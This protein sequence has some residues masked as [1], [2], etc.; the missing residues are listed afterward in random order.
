MSCVHCS[1]D[2]AALGDFNIEMCVL[3]C[4]IQAPE[5]Q[6]DAALRLL[7]PSDFATPACALVF[8]TISRRYSHGELVDPASLTAYFYD[9]EMIEQ[10]GGPVFISEC[11]VASPNPS[12]TSHYA[13]T[14]LEFSKRRQM[15][16]IGAE[17]ARA[18][19]DGGTETAE[20]R[21]GVLTAMRRADTA[22]MGKDGEEITPIKNVAFDYI[23]QMEAA[24]T[25][26]GEIDPAVATGIAGLDKLLD[27]G[28]RREYVLIGGLQ[29]H[30][31]SL[32]AMQMAGRLAVAGRRGLVIGYDMTPMQVFMRDLARE[33]QVP[34]AQIMGRVP[35]EGGPAFQRI[36]RG[37]SQI[38]GAWDVWYTKSPYTTFETATAHARS[39]HR[40]K[41]LD[42]IVLDF[43]QKVPLSKGRKDRT[44]EAL[45]ALSGRVS[46]L[47]KELGCALIAPVQ[48]NDDGMIREARG[49]LDDPQTYIRIEMDTT[50]NEDGEIESGDN[51]F[52]RVLKNRFGINQRRC[53]VFRNGPFQR[54]E[55]R[56]FTKPEPK[57]RSERS[58]KSQKRP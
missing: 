39:L 4:M 30:G 48:L 1:P 57:P 45:V 20:W 52:L 27:G 31:K 46:N 29:G 53:P 49:L 43:L 50:S 56:D 21:E 35:I 37:V 5:T 38:G 47:Q 18:A 17:I 41:P 42:F 33:I 44:D 40:Q 15:V 26:G 36:T 22:L 11:L 9:K 51:G 54:F 19:I 32:L 23:D 3:S 24:Q 2:R 13:Q 7:T 8:E 10:I 16:R 14:V 6:V 12:H 34:L 25:A 58:W 55:D 28:I